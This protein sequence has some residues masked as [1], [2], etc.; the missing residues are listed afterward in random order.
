MKKIIIPIIVLMIISITSLLMFTTLGIKQFLFCIIGL[1]LIYLIYKINLNYLIKYSFILYIINI[2]LLIL[3]LF[4][5][6]EING[7]K[8][9]IDIYNFK[10]QPSELMKIT[11]ILYISTLLKKNTNIFIILVIVLIPSILTYLEPDTGAIIIYF[12]IFITS[13]LFSNR[14]LKKTIIF[15][16]IFIL[17]TIFIIIIYF[18]YQDLFIKIFGNSIFYRIDRLINFKNNLQIENALISIGAH[19][20][21]YF[22]KYHNDFIFAYLISKFKIYIIIPIFIS[23]FYI[24]NYL[25]KHINFIN[26]CILYIF[27]FQIFQNI[28]MNIGLIPIIGIPLP[29]LSYGGSH[30]ISFSILIGIV[31]NNNYK[32]NNDNMDSNCIVDM[33]NMDKDYLQ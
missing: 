3:V 10:L 28:L 4:I 15:I 9:W 29:F 16:S 5:G 31:I 6:R 18:N 21:L 32:F 23:Y 7:S 27:I 8:A 19:N 30:I 11:L 33:N 2:I 12:I 1:I 26:I 20:Y 13:Y 22:P 25:N 14:S 17:L 24:L